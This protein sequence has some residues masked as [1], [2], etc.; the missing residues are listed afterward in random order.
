MAVRRYT[1][2][3]PVLKD[4]LRV[5]DAKDRN[6]LLKQDSKPFQF[7]KHVLSLNHCK[8]V[9]IVVK[10]PKLYGDTL[11]FIQGRVVHRWVKVTQG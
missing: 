6:L 2:S 3:I 1:I 4:I 10:I 11:N 8:I 5:R 7:E 9:T